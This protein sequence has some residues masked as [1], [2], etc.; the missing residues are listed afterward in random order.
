MIIECSERGESIL[1][2]RDDKAASHLRQNVCVVCLYPVCVHACVRWARERGNTRGGRSRRIPVRAGRECTTTSCNRFDCDAFSMATAHT[3]VTGAR[4][5]R[6]SGLYRLSYS[7]RY[8]R[9]IRKSRTE[10]DRTKR[11]IEKRISFLSE[12]RQRFF[13]GFFTT[14]IGPPFSTDTYSLSIRARARTHTGRGGEREREDI[15]FSDK[16][17]SIKTYVA[18]LARAAKWHG[19]SCIYTK[20]NVIKYVD[21]LIHLLLFLFSFFLLHEYLEFNYQVY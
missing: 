11:I 5:V 17:Y 20:W 13:R 14:A 19:V 7:S 8:A 18:F 16:N 21:F 4:F 9:P 12:D 3:I 1:F 15:E 10:R 6:C 2:S